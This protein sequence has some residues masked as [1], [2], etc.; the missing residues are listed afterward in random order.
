MTSTF[1]RPGG[2]EVLSA[3]RADARTKLLP[4]VIL[5][6]SDEERDFLAKGTRTAQTAM[7]A[8]PV[9]FNDFAAAVQRLGL[10]WLVL[11]RTPPDVALS[12]APAG[13]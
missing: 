8:S 12:R 9:E 11:N 2:L 5:T 6:S 7:C 1:P 10:Y 3:I 13:V 4:V